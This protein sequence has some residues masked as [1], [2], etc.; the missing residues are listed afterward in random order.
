MKV[1]FQDG[2]W[3]LVDHTDYTKKASIQHRCQHVQY[4]WWYFE[5]EGVCGS[6]EDECPPAL[7]GLWNLHRWDR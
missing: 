3:R 2:N 7:I 1:L 4:D 5:F 6:C